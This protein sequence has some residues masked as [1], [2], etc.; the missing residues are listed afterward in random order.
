[1]F[2]NQ[3]MNS[4]ATLYSRQD[5]FES[6]AANIMLKVLYFFVVVLAV[7]ANILIFYLL[8]RKR[9]KSTN[10]TML[11][12]HLL[13]ADTLSGISLLPY[14]FIDVHKLTI[15]NDIEGTVVCWST[16]GLCFFYAT[17]GNQIFFVCFISVFRLFKIKWRTKAAEYFTKKNIQKVSIFAWI[18]SGCL[19]IPN[20]ISWKYM[21]KDGYCKRHWSYPML[22]TVY[23]CAYFVIGL[24][25]PLV[26][27]VI[28]YVLIKK[29]L[30]EHKDSLTI[31]NSRVVQSSKKI[32]NLLRIL[33]LSFLLCWAPLLIYFFLATTTNVFP[34]GVKGDRIRLKFIRVAVL[35]AVSNTLLDPLYLFFQLKEYRDALKALLNLKPANTTKE[36][37]ITIETIA[38]INKKTNK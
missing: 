28:C 3:S 14:V 25:I 18:T 10:F 4:N 20:I 36:N 38:S 24:L 23:T 26:V 5:V 15:R 19:M 2:Q 22:G 30:N 7:T 33:F 29:T 17:G 12:H 11:L 34:N 13:I 9:I 31:V 32:T 27:F 8:I 16:I 35:V 21:A 1:M 6:A 37:E